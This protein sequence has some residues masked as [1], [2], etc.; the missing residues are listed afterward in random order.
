MLTSQILNSCRTTF[1]DDFQYKKII[2]DN[3]LTEDEKMDLLCENIIDLDCTAKNLTSLTDRCFPKLKTLIC[4]FNKINTFSINNVE[5]NNFSRFSNVKILDCSC[6]LLTKLD[7]QIEFPAAEMIMCGNNKITSLGNPSNSFYK[8]KTFICNNNLL[9]ELPNVSYP[10]LS[11]LDC[12]NNLLKNLPKT[13][14]PELHQIGCENNNITEFPR[15]TF[16]CPTI[17]PKLRSITCDDKICKLPYIPYI[18]RASINIKGYNTLYE[19]K[20]MKNHQLKIHSL[21]LILKFLYK[22][23]S[24]Y[25]S[26]LCYDV[27]NMI[28]SYCPID[29]SI[30]N[31]PVIKLTPC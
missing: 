12:Q 9:T 4:L 15:F 5:N 26:Y 7:I 21:L 8:L 30:I 28:C 17:F 22:N 2:N 24:S 16:D 19:T 6:N 11:S 1:A 3:L 31:E 27:I 20:N 29:Y 10:V 14:Y 25:F 23:K 13:I 18:D